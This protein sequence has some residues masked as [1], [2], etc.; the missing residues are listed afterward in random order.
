MGF[1]LDRARATLSSTTVRT[2]SMRLEG[3]VRLPP[4]EAAR[5][6]NAA[7]RLFEVYQSGC[8]TLHKLKTG[9]TQRILV[10][11]QQVNVGQGGRAV[12][13]GTVTRGSRTRGKGR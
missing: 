7:A 5:L 4:G 13:A 3:S 9:G 6:T 11:Q 1:F 12:V 8:L 2:C 10:Q